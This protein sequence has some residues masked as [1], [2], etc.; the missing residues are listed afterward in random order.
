MFETSGRGEDCGM[1]YRTYLPAA[2]VGVRCTVG[3]IIGRIY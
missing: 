1:D 3:L 2:H